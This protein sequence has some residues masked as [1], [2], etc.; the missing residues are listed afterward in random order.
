MISPFP[1]DNMNHPM[2]G[3][4]ERPWNVWFNAVQNQVNFGSP[5]SINTPISAATG[6]RLKSDKMRV[7]S[8]TAGNTTITANPQI[9]AGFDGQQ[10]VIE[11]LDNTKTVTISNGLG[12]SLK[13]GAT[14][15]L[16]ADDIIEFSFNKSK[17]LWIEKNNNN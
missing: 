9:S 12:V 8:A 4:L 16:G 5:P 3:K 6:I 1:D 10:I 11:G 13:S 14:F 7:I 15:V 2:T 17:D